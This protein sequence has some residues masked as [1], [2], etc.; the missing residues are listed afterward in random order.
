MTTASKNY[1]LSQIGNI[2]NTNANGTIA[3]LNTS[4]YSSNL[5][6]VGNVTITGGSAGQ[7]LTTN[8]NGTLSWTTITTNNVANA[9]YAAYAGNVTIAAQ[10]NITSVGTLT[11]LTVVGT[12]NLGAVGNITITGGSN[13][14]MLTTNG[15]GGLSWTTANVASSSQTGQFGLFLSAP[16]DIT[17]LAA[18]TGPYQTSSYSALGALLA[19]ATLGSATS[20]SAG[21]VATMAYGGGRYVLISAGN[22]AT[23]KYSTDGTTWTNG[24]SLPSLATGGSW[25]D[26]C[27]NGSVFFAVAYNPSTPTNTAATSP[28]GVTWTTRTLPAGTGDYRYYSCCAGGSTLVTVQYLNNG[29]SNNSLA[30]KSTDNG[31]TWTSA[32]TPGNKFDFVRYGGGKYITATFRSNVGYWSTDAV[33]WT[34]FT[35]P[36]T[37]DW[38]NAA[39]N[40]AYWLMTTAASADT[41]IAMSYDGINC[42]SVSTPNGSPF[43]TQGITWNG[44]RW[45]LINTT[46]NVVYWSQGYALTWSY[47]FVASGVT[48][49]PFPV[50]DGTGDNVLVYNG[51]DQKTYKWPFTKASTFSV[52]SGPASVSR[53]AWFVKS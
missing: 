2:V 4:A 45:V 28:D 38:E 14:Q 44:S 34:Q 36:R 18:N 42:T 17:W 26:M 48:S 53:G 15:S 47:S 49:R 19:T 8:G 27:W 30:A 22:T 35:L 3:S 33:T 11:G 25:T 24:G 51:V 31:A 37:G 43:T 46:D 21:T 52:G 1:S 50:S 16:P 40:G 10:S 20:G 7:A 6:P 13:G 5:G 39:H 41:T 32:S 29:I 9:N 23:S 12:T